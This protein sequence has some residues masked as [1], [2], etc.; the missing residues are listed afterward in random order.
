MRAKCG[1]FSFVCSIELRGAI[2]SRPSDLLHDAR[3]SYLLLHLLFHFPLHYMTVTT[4]LSVGH[5]SL[6]GFMGLI[7]FNWVGSGE[8]HLIPISPLPFLS[9]FSV[10]RIPATS[11]SLLETSTF[12]PKLSSLV[13]HWVPHNFNRG[14]IYYVL[15]IVK[16]PGRGGVAEMLNWG[17]VRQKPHNRWSQQPTWGL[18][19]TSSRW[20]RE[21]GI[22]S[23]AHKCAEYRHRDL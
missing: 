4:V 5:S 7:G 14:R 1:V 2:S 17:G 9:V 18:F 21:Y 8:N 22:K 12:L 11:G 10:R 20:M 19:T 3:G 13:A 15:C 23:Q 16:L 6:N